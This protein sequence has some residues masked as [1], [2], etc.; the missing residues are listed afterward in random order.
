VT[1]P[2]PRLVGIVV[3]SHSQRLADGVREVAAQMAGPDELAEAV[4][5]ATDAA[6]VRRL[7]SASGASG[8]VD[9]RGPPG[10]RYT[11]VTMARVDP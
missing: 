9:D 3:V 8:A 1:D 7:A 10:G 11:R 4:V 6:A 5:G 2:S